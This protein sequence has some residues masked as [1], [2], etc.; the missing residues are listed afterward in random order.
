MQE[1]RLAFRRF[2]KSPGFAIAVILSIGLGIGANATIFSIVSTFL[3]R[4]PAVGDPARLVSVL[5]TQR[6]DCCGNNLS[7]P[8]YNDL[9][10]RICSG[11]RTQLRG[12]IQ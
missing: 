1:I 6:G 5:T 8:L 3:L 7:W 9:R 12:M 11:A 4:P 10:D 2:S